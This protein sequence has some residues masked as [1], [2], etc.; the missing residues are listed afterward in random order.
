MSKSTED[1]LRKIMEELFRD[2][3]IRCWQNK[4][5]IIFSLRSKYGDT[6]NIELAES[7]YDQI[8]AN[9]TKEN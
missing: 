3:G 9:H 6:L 2:L 1:K 4:S 5:S 8:L 7:I